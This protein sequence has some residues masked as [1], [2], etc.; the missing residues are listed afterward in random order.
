MDFFPLISCII[1]TNNNDIQNAI[2]ISNS[3]KNRNIITA[4][5]HNFTSIVINQRG[6]IFGGTVN[7]NCY[8]FVYTLM[9]V[10]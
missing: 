8:F 3:R 4:F 10:C 2:N 9:E 1:F 6:C 5:S 7:G